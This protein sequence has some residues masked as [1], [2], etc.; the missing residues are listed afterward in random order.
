MGRKQ[1]R[2]L[3][4]LSYKQ[5][6]ARR[7]GQSDGVARDVVC[8]LGKIPYRSRKA[9]DRKMLT[10]RQ[11]PNYQDRGYPLHTYECPVCDHWHVGHDTRNYEQR[12]S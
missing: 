3:S 2:T 1:R 12:E 6:E 11:A 10:L 9:A 4:N 5:M 7:L 8:P